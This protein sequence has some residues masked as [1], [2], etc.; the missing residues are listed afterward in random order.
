MDFESKIHAKLILA[1]L[2]LCWETLWLAFAPAV[3]VAGLFLAYAGF[4]LPSALAGWLEVVA[5]SLLL[6]AFLAALAFGVCV[7]NGQAKAP[8]SAVSS[9]T[10]RFCIGR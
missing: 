5:F 4:D 2:A 1:K 7:S 6:I 10:V 8:P 9:S 3:M